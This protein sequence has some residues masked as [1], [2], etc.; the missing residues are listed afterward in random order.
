MSR[1]IGCAVVS[2]IASSSCTLAPTEPT[3]SSAKPINPVLASPT[4]VPVQ[5]EVHCAVRWLDGMGSPD[6][7]ALAN[8]SVSAQPFEQIDSDIATVVRPGV[9]APLRR[10]PIYI[11]TTYNGTWSL[12]SHSYA[13]DPQTTPVAL[14]PYLMGSVAEAGSN[15]STPLEN[16]LVEVLAPAEEVGKTYLTR[17]GSYRLNHLPMNVP[18]TIRAS[19]P[20]YITLTKTHPGITDDARIGAPLNAVLHFEL[21][22]VP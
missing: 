14:V 10:G 15:F 22:K 20:A 7:T 19:K 9:I 1:A 16:V 3:R 21:A 12:A 18:I 2:V 5:T 11:R 4:C 13:V 6:V 8:W 17:G